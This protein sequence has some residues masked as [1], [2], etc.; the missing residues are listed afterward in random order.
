MPGSRPLLRELNEAVSRGSPEKR[1]RAL[2]YLADVLTVGRFTDDD[3]WVFGKIINQLVDAIEVEVRAQIAERLA[4]IEQ[5][6][7]NAIEH[8]AFDD[9]ISVAGPVLRHSKRLSP[10]ALIDNIRSKSQRHLLA[11]SQRK[12]LPS[13]VTDELIERGNRQVLRSVAA[14]DGA[15]FSRSGFLNLVRR[16]ENDGIL[17]ER[18]GLRRDIPRHVFQQL[19]AKASIE[20]RR[21]LEAERPELFGTIQDSVTEVT[22]SLHS[23][24]G[25]ASKSY[26]EAKREIIARQRRGALKES[27]ILNDAVEHRQDEVVVALSLLCGLPANVVERALRD[28]EVTLILAKAQ[29]FAWETVVALLFLAARDHRIGA[30]DLDQMKRDYLKLDTAACGDVLLTYQSRR[31]SGI[32]RHTM[33]RPA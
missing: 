12:S 27:S 23:K 18:L 15:A 13:E 7:V 16:A 32:L 2:R 9:A 31:R 3:I 14:N 30:P 5:A 21:K 25:P 26:F 11:I 4:T 20:V 19:I 6:P 1:N 22:G 17:G 28:S 8:L 24:F 10:R 29:D 33:R